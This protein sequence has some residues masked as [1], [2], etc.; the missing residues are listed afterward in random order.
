M[1]FLDSMKAGVILFC[2]G[3][4]LFFVRAMSPGDVK[5]FFVIGFVTGITDIGSLFYWILLSGGVVATFCFFDRRSNNLNPKG[6]LL[7]LKE[8]WYKLVTLHM[9][10]SEAEK[11]SLKISRYG[12]KL[13]MPFAPSIVIGLA[14]FYYFN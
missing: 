3:L 5:L 1:L 2:A 8:R 12:D 9:P 11:K 6:F 10:M 7:S 4:V 13:V 14:M